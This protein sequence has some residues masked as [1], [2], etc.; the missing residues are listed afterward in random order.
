VRLGRLLGVRKRHEE[1]ASELAAALAARPTGPLL[2][3]AHLFA[4]RSA[5]ALG[6][7]PDAAEH[8]KSAAQLFPGAQ[9][10]QL[11][12][13]Q[14]ALLEADVPA[15]LDSVQRLDTSPTARD[16]WWWYHLASGRDADALLRE[17]WAQVRQ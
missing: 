12:L 9:S 15:A 10:A 8:Y 3:Y 4:G 13:S 1:A 7:I 16:P 5:Q 17:M 11:A 14:S 6:K 2:F